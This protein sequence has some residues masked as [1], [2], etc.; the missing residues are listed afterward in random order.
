M[1]KKDEKDQPT[2]SLRNLVTTLI[3]TTEAMINI[4]ERKEIMSRSEII[5]EIRAMRKAADTQKA[6]D[7]G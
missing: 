1:I 6:E 5:E 2:T 7:D 4:L 3:Y